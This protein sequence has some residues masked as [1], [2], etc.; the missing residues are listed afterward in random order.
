VPS[1]QVWFSEK[2]PEDVELYRKLKDYAKRRR[3]SL[4]STVKY[5]LYSFF[6]GE[7]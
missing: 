5:I 7:N 6:G 4:S 2:D 1:V 3:S